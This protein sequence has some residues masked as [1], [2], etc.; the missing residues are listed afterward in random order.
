M[1]GIGE[2]HD[3][4]GALEYYQRAAEQGMAEAQLEFGT[5]STTITRIAKKIT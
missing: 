4:D 2:H 3:Y 1:S 5:S